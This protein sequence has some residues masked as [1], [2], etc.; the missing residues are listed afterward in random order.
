MGNFTITRSLDDPEWDDFVAATEGGHHVQT[1]LWAQVKAQ[2]GWKPVRIIHK[3]QNDIAAGCQILV[4]HYPLLG[5]IGVVPKGPLCRIEDPKTIEQIIEQLLLICKRHGIKVI[6]V[7]PP[8]NGEYIGHILA[9]NN[10]SPSTLEL[11]SPATIIVDVAIDETQLY[12]QLERRIRKAIK[13]SKRAGVMVRTG[14]EE[15]LHTFY[16]LHMDTCKRQKFLPFPESYYEAMHRVLGSHGYIQL[17]FVEI[18]GE[19][20]SA[21]LII[22]FRD[23]IVFKVLGWSGK[24]KEA[25]PNAALYWEILLWAKN[26]DYHYVDFEGV[27]LEG[28]RKFLND[29]P[30]PESLINSYDF[31]K[32][33]YGGKVVI[34]P[35][36]YD[37]IFNPVYRWL[38]HRMKLQVT[39]QNNA[40]SKSIDFFRKR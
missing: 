5:N 36:P 32:Y 24:Y 12:D 7:Q 23:T 22:P 38:F 35:E 25:K 29:E 30:L 10:F 34:F 31:L 2:L 18:Q 27:N 13:Q 26:H 9:E 15:D 21:G 37:M 14:T 33:G 40:L 1:S 4:R 17:L 39:Q 3:H 11:A 16:R 28:A 8:D 20:I 6:A 19:P